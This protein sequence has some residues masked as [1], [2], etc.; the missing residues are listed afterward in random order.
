MAVKAY[1]ILCKL[2]VY[3]LVLNSYFFLPQ[4][5]IPI[6][7]LP[8]TEQLRLSRKAC[9]KEW[10]DQDAAMVPPEELNDDPTSK[11]LLTYFTR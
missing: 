10:D 11:S 5:P 7:D 9:L 1:A 3:P 4:G 8:H 2:P 6:E